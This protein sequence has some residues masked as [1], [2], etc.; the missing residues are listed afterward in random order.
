MEKY[1]VKRDG[2]PPIA[3]TGETI[4]DCVLDSRKLAEAR[5][6]LAKPSNS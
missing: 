6:A 5:A 1:S 3:F 2:L 4:A